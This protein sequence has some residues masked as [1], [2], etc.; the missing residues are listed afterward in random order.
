MYEKLQRLVNTAGKSPVT[1]K[2]TVPIILLLRIAF[3]PEEHAS[4]RALGSSK[5]ALLALPT[6]GVTDYFG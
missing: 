4:D 2:S 5:T 1:E 6:H 3:W